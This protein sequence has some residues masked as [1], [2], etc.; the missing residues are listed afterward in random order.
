MPAQECGAFDVRAFGAAGDGR[1]DDTAA[2][3]KAID[4]AGEV[5]GEVR[6][7]AGVY[8]VSTLRARPHVVLKGCATWTYNA[9]SGSEIRLGK[10]GVQCLIDMSGATGC[11]LD[12]LY[13]NG[14]GADGQPLGQDVHGVFLRRPDEQREDSIRVE[15]STVRGFSG[16]GI[17]LEKVWVFTVRHSMVAYNHGNGIYVDGWD[18][19]VLD[20]WLSANRQAG[21]GAFRQSASVT[22]TGNRI[23][24][25]HSGGIEVHGGDHYNVT[26][27][28]IDRSGGPG[29][30]L[31]RRD[32]AVCRQFAMTGNVIRRSG[33]FFRELPKYADSQVWIEGG[34]GVVLTGNT[35][36]VGQDDWGKG[37]WSPAKGIV[38]ESLTNSVIRDNALHEGAL[39]DLL[40]DLGRHGEGVVVEG[41]V[42]SLF[43]RPE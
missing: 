8:R 33:A 9:A 15:R 16:D 36:S 13:L 42:G 3:Q 28:F 10:A 11:V 40:V 43:P 4:A 27:N 32:G 14:L 37:R 29:I 24:W 6:F 35:F 18:G 34:C 31:R 7:P 17:R 38:Y 19:F 30:W 5:R 22:M 26:G 25:N 21:Y 41:N 23:E 1:S 20:T 12:G 2:V 39:D